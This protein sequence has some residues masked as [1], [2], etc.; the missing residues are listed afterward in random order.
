MMLYG[1]TAGPA[2]DRAEIAAAYQKEQVSC[3]MTTMQ[4]QEL[5]TQNSSKT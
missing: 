5:I 2:H 4:M 1:M 3:F